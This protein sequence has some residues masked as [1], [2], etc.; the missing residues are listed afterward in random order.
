MRYVI[1]IMYTA[2]TVVRS[3]M[4]LC[5]SQFAFANKQF[6]HKGVGD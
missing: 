1:C 4:S 6:V 3:V 2:Y 5:G